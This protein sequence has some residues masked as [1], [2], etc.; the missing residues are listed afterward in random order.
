MSSHANKILGI[1]PSILPQETGAALIDRAYYVL[2]EQLETFRTFLK[3][4]YAA[5]IGV[6]LSVLPSPNIALFQLYVLAYKYCVNFLED[7]IISLL[8]EKFGNDDTLLLSLGSDKPALEALIKAV[9]QDTHL[10]RLVVRSVAY[11]MRLR[12]VTVHNWSGSEHKWPGP[13]SNWSTSRYQ[14]KWPEPEDRW[15]ELGD[16]RGL[17][18]FPSRP[19]TGD[20]IEEVMDSVPSELWVPISRE[21][22]LALTLDA[23]SQ[24]FI[25]TVGHEN[26]FLRRCEIHDDAGLSAS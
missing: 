22:L 23:R 18:A 26:E 2:D 21:N 16:E 8:Y 25:S 17:P 6:T 7:A 24:D 10:Y 15:S 20:E 5:Y 13:G 12:T 1:L 19:A 4:L 3:W 9:P 11:A 14:F